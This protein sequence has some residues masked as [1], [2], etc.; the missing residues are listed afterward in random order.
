MLLWATES[1]IKKRITGTISAINNP[2]N[3]FLVHNSI[4]YIILQPARQSTINHPLMLQSCCK[5]SRWS[6]LELSLNLYSTI[7]YPISFLG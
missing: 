3:S 1:T 5:K 6:R 2:Y 4:F 7:L